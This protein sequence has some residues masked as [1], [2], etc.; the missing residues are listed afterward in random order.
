M[1]RSRALARPWGLWDPSHPRPAHGASLLSP[2][3]GWGVPGVAVREGLE[4]G[5]GVQPGVRGRG[6][7][8]WEGTCLWCLRVCVGSQ[9]GELRAF[10]CRAYVG[11]FLSCGAEHR[12]RGVGGGIVVTLLACAGVGAPWEGRDGGR[13]NPLPQ[14][15]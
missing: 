4:A 6:G 14:H 15:H 3:G 10:T 7:A 11:A 8:G 13:A 1:G 2:L 5:V 12:V 9:F